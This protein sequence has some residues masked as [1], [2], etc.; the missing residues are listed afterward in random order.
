MFRDYAERGR[1][2]K[3]A[4]ARLAP[5]TAA[6][7]R[8]A[9]TGSHAAGYRALAERSD[10]YAATIRTL[11]LSVAVPPILSRASPRNFLSRSSV[12][13]RSKESNASSSLVPA[14]SFGRAVMA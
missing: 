14:S 6:R 8:I 5:G 10:P 7:F 2:F 9:G 1:E 3:A 4:V 12:V 13:V 11:V